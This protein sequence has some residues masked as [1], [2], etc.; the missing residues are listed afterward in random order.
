MAINYKTYTDAQLSFALKDIKATMK[1]HPV[2]SSYYNELLEEHD[3]VMEVISNR[4]V[5]EY[6]KRYS[7]RPKGVAVFN[8]PT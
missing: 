8:T 3:K 6:K 5:K 7:K 2:N 4:L 1:L